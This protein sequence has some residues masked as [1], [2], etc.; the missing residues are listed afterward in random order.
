MAGANCHPPASGQPSTQ[1]GTDPYRWSSLLQLP[2]R[3]PSP[4]RR[5]WEL[6][7]LMR[8]WA[9]Y[10]P[11]LSAC[12][13]AAELASARVLVTGRTQP[14]LS[15]PLDSLRSKVESSHLPKTTGRGSRFWR[16]L[17]YGLHYHAALRARSAHQFARPT[18]EPYRLETK[19]GCDCRPWKM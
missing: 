17:R 16:R 6:A 4:P 19:K 13:R 10:P 15:V 11:H 7:C 12:R 1:E 8:R 9:R 18:V 3:A 2:D 5:P 14:L